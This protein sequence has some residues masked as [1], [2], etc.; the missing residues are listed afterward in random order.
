MLRRAETECETNWH[1][2]HLELRDRLSCSAALLQ[3]TRERCCASLELLEPLGERLPS[4]ALV[5]GTAEEVLLMRAGAVTSWKA[6][7]ATLTGPAAGAAMPESPLSL[8][9]CRRPRWV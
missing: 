6:Q 4:A 1:G 9:S 2:F 3:K 7:S 8:P 5:T